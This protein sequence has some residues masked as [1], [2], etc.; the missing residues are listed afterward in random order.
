MSVIVT[1]C[2]YQQ[3]SHPAMHPPVGYLAQHDTHFRLALL[4]HAQESDVGDHCMHGCSRSLGDGGG[5][6]TEYLRVY[7]TIKDLV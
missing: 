1:K 6:C 4:I 2:F 3:E 5:Q 7:R